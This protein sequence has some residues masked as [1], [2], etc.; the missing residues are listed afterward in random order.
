VDF[1]VVPS[2]LFPLNKRGIEPYETDHFWLLGALESVKDDAP[3]QHIIRDMNI[4]SM[5]YTGEFLFE[6]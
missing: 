4:L 5:E 6:G 2:C 1:R 3:G